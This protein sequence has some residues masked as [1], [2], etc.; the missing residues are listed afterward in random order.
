VAFYGGT[1]ALYRRIESVADE[2]TAPG[3]ANLILSF[4]DAQGAY[5][6]WTPK[7]QDYQ[8]EIRI[9][10]NG[11]A[12]GDY[13]SLVGTDSVDGTIKGGNANEQSMNLQGFDKALPQDWDV[14]VLHEFG[15]A[16]GF[17]HEHQSPAA[18]C[19]FRFD[20]DPGYVKSLDKYGW[21]TNDSAGRRPGLY[22]YL[23]GYANNWSKEK[24]DFNLR[25]LK[26]SSL[27]VVGNYD[28]KSIMEY[29]FDPFMF[30]AG[31]NSPCYIDHQS[32][33]L[34]DEDAAT[35]RAAYP[36]NGPALAA[37]D[38]AIRRDTQKLEKVAKPDTRF[39][40]SISNR[41]SYQKAALR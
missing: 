6:H 5:R 8:A 34:S 40:E 16:M 9:G 28:K 25:Q 2:W 39:A 15:H 35:V 37:I 36:L 11:A 7:D 22:T 4:K 21:Y 1:D 3:R 30:Q 14:T 20:D 29:I 26:P 10:F 33:E 31:Q 24:V 38:Y 23:G 27:Y 12:Y 13:W 19:G 18:Q 32:A 41:L 17:E